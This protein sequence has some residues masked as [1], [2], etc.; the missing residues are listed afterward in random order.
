MNWVN[1]PTNA[2]RLKR[3]DKEIIIFGEFHGYAKECE[4][5]HSTDI[6]DYLRKWFAEEKEQLDF[7]CEMSPVH[8]KYLTDDNP[9]N[10]TISRHEDMSHLGEIRQLFR[11]KVK[12]PKSMPNVRFHYFDYRDDYDLGFLYMDLEEGMAEQ[13]VDYTHLVNMH[14]SLVDMQ[15]KME[16]MPFV[17]KIRKN[18]KDE[19]VRKMLVKRLDALAI[20]KVTERLHAFIDWVIKTN[21]EV[22]AKR[23]RRY[24]P[25][26]TYGFPRPRMVDIIKQRLLTAWSLQTDLSA[27]GVKLV[28]FVFL[29]RFLDKSYMQRTVSYCGMHHLTHQ[30]EIL[31]KDFGFRLEAAALHRL[32]LEKIE[33]LIKEGSQFEHAF[34]PIEFG[35]CIDVSKVEFPPR[36]K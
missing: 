9:D 24:D 34:Y 3:D 27:L 36:A 35:Q 6:Y 13:V 1:G 29:R 23:N 20:G 11:R 26:Y 14:A 5:F 2:I 33:Q 8:L 22:L 4:A 32:P 7:F 15:K 16:D 31:V 17:R 18:T 10:L 30:L 21:N 25:Q 28:D 12:T 19:K